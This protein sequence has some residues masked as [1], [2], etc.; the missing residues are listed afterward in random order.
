MRMALRCRH[1]HLLVR[2]A[3]LA[4]AECGCQAVPIITASLC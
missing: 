3:L 4:A 2:K 1:A